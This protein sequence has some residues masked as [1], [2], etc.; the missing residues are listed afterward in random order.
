MCLWLT[1]SQVSAEV[2]RAL[3]VR[4]IIVI[5][6]SGLKTAMRF[7]HFGLELGMVFEGTWRVKQYLSFHPN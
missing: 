1:E 7:A 2:L 5:E 3:E 6:L 4:L